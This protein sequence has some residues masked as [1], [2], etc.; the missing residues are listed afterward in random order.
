MGYVNK[1]LQPLDGKALVQWV[2]ERLAPQVDSLFINANRD[3]ADY[4]AFG[5]PV[6]ADLIPDFAGP[7]AGIHRALQHV[8]HPLLATAPCDAPYLPADLVARLHQ[9]LQQRRAAQIAVARSGGQIH[10]VFSLIR[11]EALPSLTRFLADG[12]RAIK[13]WHATL[14]SCVVDFD[15]AS[16]FGNINTP[17]E[18]QTISLSTPTIAV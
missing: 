7:L 1:G 12:G 6:I 2:I 17:T 15:D 13:H 14:D 3:A 10:P 4:G 9:A 11:T 5:Y 16:A 18:L 8:Q